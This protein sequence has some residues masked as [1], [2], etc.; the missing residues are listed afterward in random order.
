MV[1]LDIFVDL[2]PN[3]KDKCNNNKMTKSKTKLYSNTHTKSDNVQ[4]RTQE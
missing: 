1:S 4:V 2:F 3:K